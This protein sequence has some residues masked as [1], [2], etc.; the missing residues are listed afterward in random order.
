MK[1]LIIEKDALEKI[2]PIISVIEGLIELGH[3]VSIIAGGANDVIKQNLKKRNVLIQ[4]I[5]FGMELSY[6]EKVKST[7]K[8]RNTVKET[9]IKNDFDLLWIEGHGTFRWMPSTV[10]E[11]NF[12]MQISELYDAKKMEVT[13]KAIR[14]VIHKA[15]A[16]VMPEFNRATL[17]QVEYELKQRPIVLSNKPYFYLTEDDEIRCKKKYEKELAIFKEKK[18]IL[19]QGIIHK[20]RD[21]SNYIKAVKELGDDYRL[22]LLGKDYGVL[23]EYRKINPEIIHIDFIPAPD[24]LYFTAH[25]Y[26]G[27]VTYEPTTLNCAYCAPNKIYEYGRYSLP[28][29]ANDIP[30]LIYTIGHAGAG[31]IVDEKS[32]ES[33]KEGILEIDKNHALYAQNARKFYDDTDNVATIEKILEV[34]MENKKCNI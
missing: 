16:I 34:A 30:G 4:T 7:I 11:K 28:M 17:Y 9:L 22:V 31:V 1:I 23:N 6:I 2:P 29:L 12:V 27:I 26:I 13:R 14:K 24:Y 8:F 18:V 33:I 15:N 5:P 32:V 21:L 19:Y 10:A 3:S 25:A 20:E